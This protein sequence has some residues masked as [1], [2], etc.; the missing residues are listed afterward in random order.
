MTIGRETQK[1][2]VVEHTCANC[3]QLI[4]NRRLEHDHIFGFYSVPLVTICW[5]LNM[6][7]LHGVLFANELHCKSLKS[8]GD[9]ADTIDQVLHP[10]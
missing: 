5:T 9:E 8:V 6:L 3:E 4:T 10:K 1:H 2:N 7:K